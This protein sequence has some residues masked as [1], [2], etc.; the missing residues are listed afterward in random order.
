MPRHTE[1]A[2]ASLTRRQALLWAAAT[3][4]L[5]IRPALAG[6]HLPARDG[7]DAAVGTAIDAEFARLERSHQRRLGLYA[8]ETGTGREIAYRANER[9]AFCSTFKAVLAAAT[10]AQ[11]A[12]QPGLLER[13]IIYTQH[14]LAS[15]SPVTKERLGGGMTVAELCAAAVQYSD[16]TAAN[17]LLHRLGGP[18]ALTAYARDV[19]NK[20]FR[21]DRYETALNTAIPGDERDTSTPADMG[22]MLEALVL[23]NALPAEARTRLK[24]WLLGNKTGDHRIRAAV[25]A[26]WQV[27][28]KTG[29]GDY[30]S[31]N[32][33]GIV[34]PPGR[35]PIVLAIYTGSRDT[36]AKA[37]ESLIAEAARIAITRLA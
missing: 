25:P 6:G 17:L 30:G 22:R 26:G 36:H 29:T 1:H 37:D 35:P 15:Y 2:S 19:G 14:D 5:W 28:D 4:L 18:R 27:A 13:R 31:A 23:G 24:T 9:F 10:L 34:W 21:L 12:A 32:D 20:S 8:L 3:P 7:D 33:F 11:D 16:N